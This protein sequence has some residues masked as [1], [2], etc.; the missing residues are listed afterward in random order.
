MI[1]QIFILAF[2]LFVISRIIA[3]FRLGD[4]T[5]RELTVW[6]IFWFLVGAATLAPQKT[7]VVARWVGVE[8]GA[9]LLV[10]LS[11]MALF[12]IVFKIVVRLEKIDKDLTIIVRHA[13]LNG[14]KPSSEPRALTAK[15]SRGGRA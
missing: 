14:G 3:R 9:D 7:D 13:A 4:V 1:I 6:L 15:E 12:F 2:I 10:Y 11:I 5:S 8:R